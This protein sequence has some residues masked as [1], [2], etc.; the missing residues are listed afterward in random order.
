MKN[1]DLE[2]HEYAGGRHR[3]IGKIRRLVCFAFGCALLTV[4]ASLY[5]L[6]ANGEGSIGA[7]RLA[8]GVF[9]TLGGAALLL[10][11]AFFPNS[12]I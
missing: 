12:R 10:W 9:P 2:P 8:L 3:Q 7:W 1:F 5:L 11:T 4:S 6:G